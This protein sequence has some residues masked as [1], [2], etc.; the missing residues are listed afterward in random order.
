MP[1]A[2]AGS[3]WSTELQSAFCASSSSSSFQLEAS[4]S[5]SSPISVFSISFRSLGSSVSTAFSASSGS[6]DIGQ[7][8]SEN[9]DDR[10]W[11]AGE[12]NEAAAY[13]GLIKCARLHMTSVHRDR[14][15]VWQLAVSLSCSELPRKVP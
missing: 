9:K 5:W 10:A 14:V 2:L 15:E 12:E 7:L 8:G 4:G 11:E 3:S 1:E 6:D 13:R